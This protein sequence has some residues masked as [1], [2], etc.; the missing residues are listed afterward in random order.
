MS[1]IAP[2]VVRAAFQTAHVYPRSAVEELKRGVSVRDGGSA[3]RR[4]SRLQRDSAVSQIKEL[5]KNADTMSN[6]DVICN[7]ARS[8]ELG[9]LNLTKTHTHT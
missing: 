5:G 7:V 3:F 4:S 1:N 6:R 8:T 2:S 9:Q